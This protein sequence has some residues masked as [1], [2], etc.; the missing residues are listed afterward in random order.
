MNQ[1]L[2]FKRDLAD[3]VIRQ[4]LRQPANL[5]AFLHQNNRSLH[6]LLGE[7]A[8]PLQRAQSSS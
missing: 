7:P 5:R 1:K 8:V 6:D 2:R 4:A 3:R